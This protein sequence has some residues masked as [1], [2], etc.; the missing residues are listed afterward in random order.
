ME[1]NRFGDIT[2]FVSAAAYTNSFAGTAATTLYDIDNVSA[3]LAMQ[4]PPN[5]GTLALV[6][7]LNVMV[8]GDLGMDIAGG[9]NGL[10]LA[11]LRTSAG[12]PSSLYR[13]DLATGAATM[14]NGAATP[15]TSAIGNG[16]VGLR[17]IAIL[18][19]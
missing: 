3:S 2:A 14:V 19:K 17:D 12:G 4:N 10:A 15:A 16:Q 8:M 9:A 18:I 13:I 5:D 11:A 7:P 6:G 1:P